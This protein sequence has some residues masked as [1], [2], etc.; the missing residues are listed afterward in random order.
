MPVAET[1]PALIQCLVTEQR[2]AVLIAPPGAGKTTTVPLALLPHVAGRILMLEPRRLAARAAAQRMASL[3]GETA[4]ERIGFRTRLESA[5]SGRTVVEVITEGLLTSRLLSDPGLTG[6]DLVIFDEIHERSAE[7]D[8]ALALVLDLQRTLRPDL[9]ILAMSATAEGQKFAAILNGPVIESAGKIFP[10]DVTHSK[11]DI[12]TA[13]DLPD[14]AAKAIR[15]I[16][17]THA[18]DILVFLPG[19]A[20]IRRCQTAL[21]GIPAAVLPLHGDLSPADQDLA[22]R[23]QDKRRIVLAT[24][25]AETSLTVPGVRIVIDGGFRRS[26]KLDPATG[27]TRLVTVRISKAAAAQRAGRAGRQGPG[28]AVRLWSEA[29]HRGLTNFEAPEIF[30]AELSG[31][32]LA[33]AAWGERP[34]TLPFPDPPPAGAVSAAR[35][36]LHELGA[37]ADGGKLTPLGRE[38]ARLRAAPRL[39]AIMCAAE[40]PGEKALAA[41]LAAILEERDV[42]GRDASADIALRLDA[43]A[44]RREGDRA[45]IAR[46]RHAARL[47]RNRIGVGANVP[48]EGDVG[49]V[50]AAGFVDRIGQ[51]RGARGAYRLSGGGSG[52]LGP[53]DPLSARKFVVAAS[54]DAKG[55]VIRLAA[56]LDAERLPASVRARCV[57]TRESGFEPVSG[58]VVVRER[59]R[60]GALILADRAQ[61][62]DAEETQ[63]ALA[64][65]IATRMSTALDWSE[66]ATNFRARIA[67]MRRL[68]PADWPDLSDPALATCLDDWLTP[69]LAGCRNIRDAK[70]IDILAVLRAYVGETLSRRLDKLL[71]ADCRLPRA[72]LRIDYTGA[73][74]TVSSRAQNFYGAITLPVL[75]E[76]RVA[77]QA[78]LLSPAGRPV[79][80]TGDLAGFWQGGWK[81]VRKDMRGRYPRHDWPENPAECG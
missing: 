78:A 40:S 34:E 38:M 2:N 7:A 63:A 12:A 69:Y 68:E 21:T 59:I 80:V 3:L 10:V 71:P 5:V 43:L 79:A 24:S 20:E 17:A 54:I 13:K 33:C 58:S 76:G 35:A 41:D 51:A 49:A 22:L 61:P 6:I 11:R 42:L 52:N 62:A 70:D 57:T 72:T 18:G 65:A 53:A 66:A 45:G 47:Y 4:G 60:L 1:L 77:L 14:A 55:N 50:L 44:G 37:F 31:L 64:A 28:T 26:P 48:A 23:E 15:D 9:R 67:V 29:L 39:A 8:L 30:D 27:L 25:I 74:A 36:L 56:G 19:M 16:F 32:V 81:D 73:V 46:I 75:A